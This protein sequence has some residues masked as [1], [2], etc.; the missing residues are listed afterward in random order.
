VELLGTLQRAS[1][2]QL[3]LIRSLTSRAILCRRKRDN[4]QVVI[5]EL[6]QESMSEEDR[7]SSINE[8]RVLSMLRHPNIIGY[9]DSFSVGDQERQGDS[10]DKVLCNVMEEDMDQSNVP[11]LMIVM[12]YADGNSKHALLKESSLRN[13]G[14]TLFDY[15]KEQK[16]LLPE[17]VRSP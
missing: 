9:F 1:P 8:I 15:L 13:Q 4:A 6:Q 2:R 11:G 10:G 17:D 7:K 3:K 16:S 14:G 5:K 12:E